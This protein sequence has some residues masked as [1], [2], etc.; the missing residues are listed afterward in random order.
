[1]YVT[2]DTLQLFKVRGQGYSSVKQQKTLIR[3]WM[4]SVTSNLAWRCN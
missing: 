4:G 3:Q 2:G 1:M